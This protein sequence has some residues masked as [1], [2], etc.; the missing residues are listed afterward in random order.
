MSA[1]NKTCYHCDRV[2]ADKID[3]LDPLGGVHGICDGCREWKAAWYA[4][5]QQRTGS[6]AANEETTP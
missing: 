4:D 6:A 5:L 2:L 3:P 1:N